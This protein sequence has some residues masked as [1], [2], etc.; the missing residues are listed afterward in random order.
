MNSH[1]R[2]MLLLLLQMVKLPAGETVKVW[3]NRHNGD[4]L[5]PKDCTLTDVIPELLTVKLHHTSAAIATDAEVP[6]T[7]V[8]AVWRSSA[9]WN[10]A[11]DGDAFELDSTKPQRRF[12]FHPP[13]AL[14]V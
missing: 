7:F 11:I 5:T 8:R 4:R 6:L 10:L 14:L 9:G 1:E 12:G 2:R 13:G 3:F